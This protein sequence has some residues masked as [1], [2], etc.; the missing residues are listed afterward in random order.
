MHKTV[1]KT[2]IAA[3]RPPQSRRSLLSVSVVSFSPT[4]HGYRGPA[5]HQMLLL[6]VFFPL[7]VS[8]SVFTYFRFGSCF[9]PRN[10]LLLAFPEAIQ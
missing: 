2:E 8:V 4:A 3:R 7:C 9:L 6:S 1:D 10:V 5:G